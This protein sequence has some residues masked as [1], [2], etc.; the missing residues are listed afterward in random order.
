MAK[1]FEIS[2][3]EAPAVVLERAK[4]AAG[5]VGARFEGDEAGGSFNGSGVS[6]TY[7]IDDDT[8][9]LTITEKPLGVPWSMVEAMATSFFAAP[10]A[11]EPQADGPQP[12]V[13]DTARRARAEEIIQEHLLWS[14]GAGLVP[15]FF[16]DIT[17]VTALQVGML[18]QLSALYGVNH[19]HESGKIFVSA[20][21]GTGIAK[22]GA[23]ALKLI[24]G[25]GTLIGG[26]SMSVMSGASTYA[27]G[28]VAIHQL[29]SRGNLT[30][31]DLEDAKRRF[32][33]AF[34]TGKNVVS[35]VE[36]RRKSE[37]GTDPVSRLRQ[38]KELLDEGLINQDDYEK[39]R[40]DIIAEM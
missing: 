13:D 29:D 40:A 25:I 3:S 39:K 11:T 27:L 12:E 7:R 4:A 10:E 2:I 18:K 38:L 8:V 17:A 15:I 1:T 33:E 5:R 32:E 35:E 9:F 20:L 37:G 14:M 34:E 19:D 28:Q 16:F 36:K 22:I 23:T 24:P 31:L 6:G 21:T 26:I 30:D